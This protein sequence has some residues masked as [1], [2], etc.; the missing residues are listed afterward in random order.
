MALHPAPRV[1]AADSYLTLHYRVGVLARD[2]AA[3]GGAVANDIVS[4]FDAQPA[5]LQLGADQLSPA[6]EARLQG[7]TVGEHR[8]FELA[9]GVAFGPRNPELVQRLDRKLL[10]QQSATNDYVPGDVVE[11]NAPG[12][13]RYAGVFRAIDDDCAIFDFNHPLAGQ[14]VRFEVRIVGIL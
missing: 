3:I 13:G 12:G 11:F 4:T 6:L 7:L 9:P 5:T 2:G 1:V 8:V 14:P 10:E